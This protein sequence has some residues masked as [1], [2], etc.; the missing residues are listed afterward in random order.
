MNLQQQLDDSQTV[1][2]ADGAVLVPVVFARSIDE[3]REYCALL[4]AMDIPV[5]VGDGDSP[6]QSPPA[7]AG[8]PVLVPQTC[9]GLASEIIASHEAAN[10]VDDEEEDGGFFEDDDDD[11]DLDDD[12]D[13]DDFLDD[14]DDDLEDEDLDDDWED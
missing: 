2:L 6:L 5:R 3:A 13:E 10:A 9:H 4:S 8:M 11:D 12:E 1:A 14:S 7:A